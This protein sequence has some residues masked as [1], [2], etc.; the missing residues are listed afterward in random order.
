MQ[1]ALRPLCFYA[2]CSKKYMNEAIFLNCEKVRNSGEW[3]FCNFKSIF[4]SF[5]L[6][7]LHSILLV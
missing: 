4:K 1:G 7:S 3:D 6:R 5:N 2:I